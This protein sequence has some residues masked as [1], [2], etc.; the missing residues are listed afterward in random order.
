V[1]QAFPEIGDIE[2]NPLVVYDQGKGAKAVD[3]RFCCAG[4]KKEREYE[5]DRG[6]ID[7]QERR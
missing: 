5:E 1:L 2:I 3:A 7:G 4:P 6:G